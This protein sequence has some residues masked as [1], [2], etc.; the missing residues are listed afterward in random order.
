M[1]L[2]IALPVFLTLI[3]RLTTFSF[4]KSFFVFIAIYILIV[5]IATCRHYI[6]YVNQAHLKSQAIGYVKYGGCNDNDHG[7]SSWLS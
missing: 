5:Y 3:A 7:C 6:H 2:I 1:K 4:D